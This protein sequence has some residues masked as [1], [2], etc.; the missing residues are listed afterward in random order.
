MRTQ[1]DFVTQSIAEFLAQGPGVAPR[2]DG[3]L[4]S[5]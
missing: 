1:V 2:A 3:G 5:K 4:S